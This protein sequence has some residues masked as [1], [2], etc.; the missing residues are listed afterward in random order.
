MRPDLV[1]LDLDGTII[2]HRGAVRQALDLWLPAFGQVSGD[3]LFEAWIAAENRHFPAWRSREISFAE[4]RRR[5]LRDF[6]PLIG[7]PVGDEDELDRVF[8]GYA[9][10]YAA[11]W[12]A[13]PDAEPALEVLAASG[14]RLAVLTN[15][16]DEQ[17][18]AKLSAVGLQ[19]KTGP[20]FS[21]EALGVAKPGHRSYLEVCDR[22]QAQPSRTVHV[23]DL[24]DLDV[25][26]PR[27]AG[28]QA[29]HL[30]RYDAGPHTERLR[31]SSLAQVPG[32]IAGI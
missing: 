26:A 27:Q 25:V 20:V 32:A 10:A 7:Q 11:S 2:D 21:S 14:V 23:G 3:E 1:I 8:D 18:N 4:Q 15:G 9:S 28:L 12:A 16:T 6:L 5:R 17:Q 29:V 30:D 13:Y 22:M 31:V 24:H 19:G